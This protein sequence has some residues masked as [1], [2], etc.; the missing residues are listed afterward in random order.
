M[1]AT[2][3]FPIETL[4]R[5]GL[6]LGG[7]HSVNGFVSFE[8]SKHCVTEARFRRRL[9]HRFW[10]KLRAA[11]RKTAGR[12]GTAARESI[13]PPEQQFLRFIT[14][15][16]RVPRASGPAI[17]EIARYED[18][19]AAES[20][21]AAAADMMRRIAI[22]EQNG[23][24]YLLSTFDPDRPQI[25]AQVSPGPGGEIQASLR[26]AMFWGELVL[27]LFTGLLT[28]MGNIINRS[29]R[30][31]GICLKLAT[32]GRKLGVKDLF[33]LIYWLWMDGFTWE[34]LKDAAGDMIDLSFWGIIHLLGKFAARL[35]PGAGQALLLADL[36]LIIVELIRKL[37]TR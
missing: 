31:R 16:R 19:S 14:K 2:V 28:V 17:L 33:D 24:G 21:A 18:A 7:V 5:A 8:P 36:G 26:E 34:C 27:E 12:R 35:S 6:N 23:T 25:F 1:T 9:D 13:S 11:R 15:E 37:V 4:L 30:L 20:R 29:R 22:V 3:R 32:K 10:K